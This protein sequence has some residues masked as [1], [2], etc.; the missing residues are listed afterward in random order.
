MEE[1][2]SAATQGATGLNMIHIKHRIDNHHESPI[3][4]GIVVLNIGLVNLGQSGAKRGNDVLERDD[5]IVV[6]MQTRVSCLVHHGLSLVP[7]IGLNG[8]S[9]RTH[10]SP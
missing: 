5:L 3:A 9:Q 4:A 10:F 1:M 7:Y 6:A 2:S 8:E